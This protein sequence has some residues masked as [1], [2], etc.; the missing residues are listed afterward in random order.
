[1]KYGEGVGMRNTSLIRTALL[2]ALIT[3]FGFVATG[4]SPAA[5]SPGGIGEI[6][7]PLI[8]VVVSEA[9]SPFLRL[10]W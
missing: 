8:W 10:G 2:I 3:A 5:D 7:P 1:M 4:R 6:R 9:N